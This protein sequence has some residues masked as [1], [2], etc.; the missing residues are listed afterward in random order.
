MVKFLSNVIAPILI[1]ILA[2]V[3]ICLLP[4]YLI[5]VLVRPK[6]KN[7]RKL[8]YEE[9]SILNEDSIWAEL[10]ITGKDK[11]MDF[12]PEKEFSDRYLSYLMD[13]A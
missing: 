2:L 8:S 12:D 3:V 10:S 11:E 6:Y 1:F 7:D 9:W 13:L 4:L 5:W